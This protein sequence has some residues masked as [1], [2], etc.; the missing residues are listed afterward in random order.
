VSDGALHVIGTGSATVELVRD[1]A[2]ETKGVV[3]DASDC[4][5]VNRWD[6]VER[7]LTDAFFGLREA[8]QRG[9]NAVVVV[10]SDDELGRRGAPAA[11]LACALTSAVRSLALEDRER[12]LTANV[13][14]VDDQSAA[15]V[16]RAVRWLLSG[17]SVTGQV[18]ALGRGHLGK[19]PS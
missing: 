9:V 19:V 16:V 3:I 17:G 5:V 14:A 12:K 7:I 15:D 13:V 1:V 11:M 6:D 10:H 2:H 4:S 18:I 8:K